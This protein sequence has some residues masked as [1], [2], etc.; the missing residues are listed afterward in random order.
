MGT[1]VWFSYGDIS[2]GVQLLTAYV[3][4]DVTSQSPIYDWNLTN[5]ITNMET[6]T[7]EHVLDTNSCTELDYDYTLSWDSQLTDMTLSPKVLHVRNTTSEKASL[8][9][10]ARLNMLGEVDNAKQVD[11]LLSDNSDA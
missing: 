1:L 5:G 2:P 6:N 9:V 10:E 4:H 8:H 7:L 11:Q 3:V